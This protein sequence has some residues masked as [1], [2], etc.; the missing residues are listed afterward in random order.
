MNSN[1][2]Q[3]QTS[4]GRRR[5]WVFAAWAPLL[6]LAIWLGGT[7]TGESDLPT[8]VYVAIVGVEV[9][10]LAAWLVRRNSMGLLVLPARLAISSGFEAAT[11]KPATPTDAPDVGFKHYNGI[12]YLAITDGYNYEH[13]VAAL[14][15]AGGAHP[16]H[17]L[18]GGDN[19]LLVRDVTAT[20]KSRSPWR[21]AG[22]S[23]TAR[24]DDELRDFL[25]SAIRAIWQADD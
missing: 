23:W 18:L 10:V 14:V 6:P 20:G 19:A 13:R 24:N 12:S 22:I 15:R 21:P 5:I 17:R 1:G 4:H 7:V 3:Y 2:V 9:L 25:V 11:V 16:L 8:G